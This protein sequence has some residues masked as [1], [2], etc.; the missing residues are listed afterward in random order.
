MKK[1]ILA[2][3]AALL[4]TSVCKAQDGNMPYTATFSS[5]F[6]M[7][8]ANYSKII[9]TLWKDFENNTLDNHV[10][11]ITDTVTMIFSQGAPVKGK[12]ENLSGAKAYR[13][14]LKDYK[15][16]ADAWMSVQSVDKNRN[17]VCV[18]GTESFTDKDGKQ[19]KHRIHEVWGFNK[20]G[21][22]DFM[23]QYAGEGTM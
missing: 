3:L 2:A 22:V 21:K 6:K 14:S 10:D 11:M 8:N 15:V 23:M 13:G 1:L 4:F 17:F 19:I 5:N 18:W 7:A 9:L 16:T 20:D 12:A